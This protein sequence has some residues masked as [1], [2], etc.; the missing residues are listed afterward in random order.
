EPDNGLGQFAWCWRSDGQ[1]P[2]FG[3]E[4]DRD[5]GQE[6]RRRQRYSRALLTGSDIGLTKCPALIERI[7]CFA[8]R[9][10]HDAEE[11]FFEGDCARVHFR[12]SVPDLDDAVDAGGH[13]CISIGC[14]A[15]AAYGTFVAPEARGQL[16]GGQV[17]CPDGAVADSG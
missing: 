9:G 14:D 8:I 4:G 3:C 7:Q 13:Q 17:P 10:K 5:F 12:G 11:W 1:N 15:E 6:S 2:G 16:T